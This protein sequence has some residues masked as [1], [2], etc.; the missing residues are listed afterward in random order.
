MTAYWQENHA[1]PLAVTDLKNLA[2][3]QI[4]RLQKL[5]SQAYRLL[6]RLGCYRYQDVST[7]PTS[8]LLSLLWDVEPEQHRQIIAS[9][10]NRS[11]IECN[12]GKYWLHPVIRAEAI[13]R[14]RNSDDWE[15][16]NHKAAEF[17]TESVQKIEIFQH[18]LQALEAYY[19]YIEINQFELAGKLIIKTRNNQ[20][21]QFLTLGSTLY[22]MG[23]VQPVLAATIHIINNIDED[24]QISE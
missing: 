13:Y 17:W 20:W 10:K 21:G 3:S 11:L 23:L 5:D 9:L 1:D 22:R 2:A 4:N 12:K 24:T 7:V 19:H 8:A 6:C 15:L 16:A 14:L 18:A